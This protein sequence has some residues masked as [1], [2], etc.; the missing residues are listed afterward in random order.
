MTRSLPRIDENAFLAEAVSQHKAG[1]LERARDLYLAILNQHPKHAGAIF[2]LGTIALQVEQFDK[3]ADFIKQAIKIG[4]ATAPMYVN[5]GAALRNLERYDKAI[6]AFNHALKLDPT[7]PGAHYNKGRAL[8]A[9]KRNKEARDCYREALA[10]D[11]NDKEAW[12]NLGTVLRELKEVD[13]ALHAFET[14]ARL[15]P[16][17]SAAY[18]NGAAILFDRGLFEISTVLIDKAI[19]LDPDNAEY[20]YELTSFMLRSG[21]LAQGWKDFD[22]RFVADHKAKAARRHEPPPYWNG[23]ALDD[24]NILLWTEQGLGEEILCASILPDILKLGGHY[25]LQCSKRMMPLIKRSFK[26]LKVTNW[27]A[28]NETVTNANPPFDLQFPAMSMMRIVRPTLDSIV[29]PAPFLKPDPNLYRDLRT[30]YEKLADGRRIVGISWRSKNSEIGELKTVPLEDWEPILLAKDVFFVNLQYG[31]CADEIMSINKKL[32]VDIY[33][34]SD[35][36]ALGELDPVLAQIAATD[37]VVTASN[38][39]VHFAG[40]MSVPTW[41][42]LPKARGLIWFWFMDRPDSPWYSSVR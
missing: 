39:N 32:G 15:D 16:N 5:L 31:E 14:A 1:N 25:T 24:K 2:R 30:K 7:Q 13:E 38:S 29:S 6:S 26:G 3:A 36:D 42:I 40:S 28:H 8:Q 37:L 27:S 19:E 17:L 35:I 21:R 41:S 22:L 11:S 9:D 34:D 4:P 20:R 18:G 33:V 23:E 10:L 12:I